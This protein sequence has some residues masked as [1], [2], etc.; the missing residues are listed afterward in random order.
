VVSGDR[1][2]AL[3]GTLIKQKLYSAIKRLIASLNY[4]KSGFFFTIQ[5][6]T[7]PIRNNTRNS[8]A[9]GVTWHCYNQYPK[10]SESH[11]FSEEL[12]KAPVTATKPS[13]GAVA[14][15]GVVK[16]LKLTTTALKAPSEALI[17]SARLWH[18]RLGYIGLD[19]LKKTALITTGMPSFQKIRPEHLACKTCDTAKMLRRPLKQ[20]I[21][22][23]LYALGRLEGDIFIIRPTL[24]NGRPYGL[25]LVDRKTRFRLL[26]LLKSKDE[27]V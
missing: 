17:Q 26:W 2:Y 3:G 4:E 15:E 22:D 13:S 8:Q 10:P 16:P 24:L 19:L 7:S 12:I 5:G 27:A 21:E 14:T 9:Y 20:P 1:L 25:I 18:V 11:Y 6:K 23:P